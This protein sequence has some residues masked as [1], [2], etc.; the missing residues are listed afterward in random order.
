MGRDE[1]AKHLCQ[2]DMAEEQGME[3]AGVQW[4]G[5]AGAQCSDV[6]LLEHL[7]EFMKGLGIANDAFE[8]FL[9]E[10]FDLFS[11]H[12]LIPLS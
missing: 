9:N 11:M 5:I 8:R 2:P 10:G 4:I 1:I 6:G 12:G 7:V 3:K